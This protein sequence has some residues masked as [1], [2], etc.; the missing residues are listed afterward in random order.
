MYYFLQNVG[1]SENSFQNIELFD[2]LFYC[3]LNTTLQCKYL[4]KNFFNQLDIHSTHFS[5]LYYK[6]KFLLAYKERTNHFL[7]F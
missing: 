3:H 7:R 6:L 1:I 2:F 5:R 4:K